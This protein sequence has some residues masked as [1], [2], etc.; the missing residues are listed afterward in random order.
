M[1]YPS[2]EVDICNLALDL[3]NEASITNFETPETRTEV[4]C[5]RHYQ[6][7]RRAVLR[8]HTWNFAIKRAQLAKNSTAP[9]YGYDAA[10]NIPNDY[11]RVVELGEFGSIKNYSIENNQILVDAVNNTTSS[12]DVLN[13]RYVYDFTNV[14]LMEALFI[15]TFALHLA[16]RLCMPITNNQAI[17][18]RLNEQWE[19]ISTVALSVDGQEDPPTRKEYSRNRAA[20]Y[21][22][23]FRTSGGIAG[24]YTFF[25]R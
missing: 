17:L 3:I 20:R 4:I 11:I 19:E 21:G 7:A 25:D 16:Q 2:S 24:T 6:L 23:R 13:M 18:G 10:Y 5:K 9:L 22:N 12:T 8:M 14:S 15:E 1:S